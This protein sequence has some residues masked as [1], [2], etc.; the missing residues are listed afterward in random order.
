MLLLLLLAIA[1]ALQP[2]H[3]GGSNP[4]ICTYVARAEVDCQRRWH[5]WYC[6][7]KAMLPYSHV[8]L[9]VLLLIQAADFVQQ[10]LLAG[11][12]A[13]RQG[14]RQ[15]SNNCKT[16]V[17]MVQSANQIRSALVGTGRPSA[18]GVLA[19]GCAWLPHAACCPVLP[20]TRHLLPGPSG[21][22]HP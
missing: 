8:P 16:A 15:R 7:S 11:P 1:H 21:T 20:P 5:C 3:R 6:L 12:Y 19:L 17:L 10:L 2:G 14:G 13:G 9:H 22:T 4:C 18:R